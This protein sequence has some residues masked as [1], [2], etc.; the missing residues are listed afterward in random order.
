LEWSEE[1]HSIVPDEIVR[2]VAFWNITYSF[3]RSDGLFAVSAALEVMSEEREVH[4]HHVRT[5][6]DAIGMNDSLA[7][8]LATGGEDTG[9]T[10]EPDEEPDGVLSDELFVFDG[11]VASLGDTIVPPAD[12]PQKEESGWIY[13]P[14]DGGGSY[15][16]PQKKAYDPIGTIT[17]TST[18]FYGDFVDLPRMY[19]D[20]HWNRW[21]SNT[22]D[23]IRYRR[24]F[25]PFE[26][27][28][29]FRLD[30]EHTYTWKATYTNHYA[31]T[32]VQFYNEDPGDRWNVLPE[33]VSLLS[34]VPY[35]HRR[36]QSQ[37][38][39]SSVIYNYGGTPSGPT[40]YI[41]FQIDVGNYV[42]VSVLHDMRCFYRPPGISIWDLNF[43]HTPA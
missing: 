28:E 37:A 5:L 43:S 11:V 29:T 4:L 9:D 6:S 31:E 22:S 26:E 42:W 20:Y 13:R 18:R 35:L 3:T 40:G 34:G 27:D 39:G 38:D 25:G 8:E 32:W 16:I 7:G 41:D 2:E 15:I 10:G 21:F 24:N 1:V 14:S 12:N 33:G 23:K 19:Y 17:L 36:V 30:F